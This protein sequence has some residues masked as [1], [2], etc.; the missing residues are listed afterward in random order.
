[1]E[2]NL[3]LKDNWKQF[4]LLVLVN[5]LVGGMVGLERTVVPLVGSEEFKIDSDLVIFSFIIAFGI[6]KAFTNLISGVLAD[7]YTRK[8]IL[9]LGWLIGVPVPFCLAWG[10]T[11]NWIIAANILLGISQGLAWSMTV[12]MKI[13]LV[14]PKKRGL[15]MGLNEA[16]GYGAVGLTALLTGYWASE[17][18]LRP[19]PFY[20]GIIYT[21]AG[22]LLSIIVITDTRKHAQLEAAQRKVTRA[23]E[24]AHKPSF[25]WVFRET[26]VKNTNLLTVSQAGLINNLNDGMSWGVF[27]LLFISAGVGLEGVGWI[28]A[29]Y[30]VV[31]GVG[32]IIT[33]PLADRIGRKPLI[34]WGMFVQVL[35]HIVIGLQILPPL[36]SGLTGSILLGAGTAMVYPALL[37]AVSDAAHP[38]WRASALG[39]YRFWRDIGYGVG[40]I[41]AGIIAGWLGIMWAVHVAGGLTFLSGVFVWWKMKESLEVSTQKDQ[42]GIKTVS[43]TR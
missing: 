4:L 20:I 8:K 25:S 37:A 28:K 30:P 31:W 22:L 29:V 12:N 5:M 1:M 9:I 17:Y 33:G 34:V 43:T 39:V 38:T 14:G 35:G 32:Q 27:P 36:Q 21:V 10:P 7:K 42:A 23:G 18:G 26:T 19:Y 6:V 15:A 11:W 3:G 13:D 2:V 24:Q 16:A 40:A 41:M